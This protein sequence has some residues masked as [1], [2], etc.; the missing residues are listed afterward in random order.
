LFHAASAGSARALPLP[1]GALPR[2]L[3]VQDDVL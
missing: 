2:D 1:G 3:H